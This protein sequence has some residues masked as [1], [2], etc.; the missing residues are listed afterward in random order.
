VTDRHAEN[1][2]VV[3]AGGRTVVAVM[4]PGSNPP[5]RLATKVAVPPAPVATVVCPT[6]V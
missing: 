1:S 4:Y 2:E 6:G 3:F 5:G